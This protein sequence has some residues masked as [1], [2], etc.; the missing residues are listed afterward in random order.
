MNTEE[1][2]KTDMR[3]DGQYAGKDKAKEAFI[4]MWTKRIQKA[5]AHWDDTAFK[6]MRIDMKFARGLQYDDQEDLDDERYIANLTLRHLAN[7][8]ASLYA[9]NPKAVAYRRERMNYKVWD[10]NPDKLSQAVEMVNMALQQAPGIPIIQLPMMFPQLAEPVALLQD[11]QEGLEMEQTMDKIGKTLELVYENQLQD[12]IPGFKKQMK[13]LVRRVLTTGVGY[14]KLGFHRLYEQR[15]EHAHKINDITEQ[16]AVLEQLSADAADNEIQEHEAAM[17]ELKQTMKTVTE[18]A[19]MIIREGLDVDFPQATSII[20]DPDCREIQ[21]FIGARWVAQEF[22]LSVEQV[23]RIYKVDLSHGKFSVYDGSG[24][25]VSAEVAQAHI[26][27]DSQ[28]D[29]GDDR[30]AKVYELYDRVSGR[31]YVIADGYCDYL[32]APAEP[33]VKLEQFFPFFPLVFNAVEDEDSL[34]PPSDVFLMRDMQ[35][36]H[37]ISRQRLREHRDAN[38]P[39][40]AASKGKMTEDDKANLAHGEAHSVVELEGLQPNE[41]LSDV[42]G[43]VPN[44]PIDPNLY[45]VGSFFDDI[46][47][48]EGTQEANLGG[49]S[50]STATETAIAE[51]SRASSIG[52]NVDDLDDFLTDVAKSASQILLTELS[53][54]TVRELVGPGAVWPELT[55]TEIAQE[56]WLTVRAGS[57]GKPNRA[58]EIQNFERMAPTLMQIPGISPAWLAKEAVERLDDRINLAEAY[59]GNVPSINAQNSMAGKPGPAMTN[60]PREQGGQGA[61]GQ[62]VVADQTDTNMGPN[63]AATSAVGPAAPQIP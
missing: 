21:G 4:G 3:R 49:T 5:K 55:A 12:Q 6:Q 19:E 2:P 31:V 59:L 11:A 42:L 25:R 44:S 29:L 35:I 30:K 38:R 32:T 27:S 10:G 53:A 28:S 14:L 13:Q 17:E 60:D 52:S 57:S 46:L 48:V 62:E 8:T 26:P 47:K 22:L 37:N 1:Q 61:A 39:K 34:F 23:K 56:L 40:Y 58:Q 20:I 24:E 50:G 41:K 36:E 33:Y 54:D 7:K 9:K 16:L 63:N 43:A 15:P 51:Q 18:Q 45:E